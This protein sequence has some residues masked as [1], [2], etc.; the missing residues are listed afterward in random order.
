MFVSSVQASWPTALPDPVT[1]WKIAIS[2]PAIAASI[3]YGRFAARSAAPVSE[4]SSIRPDHT[5]AK[6]IACEFRQRG[7]NRNLH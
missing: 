7:M 5:M 4:R 2:A 6:R 3:D 1:I